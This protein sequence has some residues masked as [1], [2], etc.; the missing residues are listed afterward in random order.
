MVEIVV[1]AGRIAHMKLNRLPG[2]HQIPHGD[3]ARIGIGTHDVAHQKIPPLKALLIFTRHQHH[4]Q[5][6]A[7]EL[8]IGIVEIAE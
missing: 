5:A 8:P 3:H 7:H 4:M 2:A 1:G 6:R